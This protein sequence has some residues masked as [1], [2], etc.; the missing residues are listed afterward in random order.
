MEAGRKLALSQVASTFTS[1]LKDLYYLFFLL[2]LYYYYLFIFNYFCSHFSP[3]SDQ[4]TPENTVH[5]DHAD[6]V[7]S[8]GMSM[9]SAGF[10]RGK[11]LF[12]LTPTQLGA[13]GGLS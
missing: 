7:L 13:P 12:T 4:T 5:R 11:G 2:T 9:D 6:Q 8:I 10:F 3:G 1:H